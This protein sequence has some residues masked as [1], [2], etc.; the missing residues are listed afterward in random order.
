MKPRPD[1]SYDGEVTPTRFQFASDTLVY[2]VRLTKLSVKDSTEAL[3]Y[4]QTAHKVDL[5]GD[6]T[7]QYQWVPMLQNAK[8][9]YQKGIFG[10]NELPGKADDWIAAIGKQTPELLAKG[11]ALGFNFVSGQRPT[12]NKDGRI[13]TTLEWARKLSEDDIKV[14]IGDAPYT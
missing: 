11:Q 8:G 3:F 12:P 13:A 6:M 14:L 4:I 5:P 10:P 1:G 7:Y 9:W 2:P